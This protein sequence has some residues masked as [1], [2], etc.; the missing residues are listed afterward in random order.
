MLSTEILNFKIVSISGYKNSNLFLFPGLRR[1]LLPFSKIQINNYTRPKSN[2]E[3]KLTWGLFF[4]S[5]SVNFSNRAMRNSLGFRR[6]QA[7]WAIKILRKTP[8]TE[9]SPSASPYTTAKSSGN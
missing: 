5:S 8:P 1:I 2:L 4:S 7:G 3:T 6:T 9:S